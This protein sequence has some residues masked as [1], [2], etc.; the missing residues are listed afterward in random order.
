VLALVSIVTTGC[1]PA[2]PD[3]EHDRP[4]ASAADTS[5][6]GPQRM[7]RFDEVASFAIASRLRSAHPVGDYAATIR[8]DAAA[9]GYGKAGRGPMPPGAMIVEALSPLPEAAPT[10]YYAMV[11]REPGF[12][13]EGGDWEYFVID[14]D[15][16]VTSS[17]K[18]PLCARCH[19]E[20]GREHL[21]EHVPS[22][23]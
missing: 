12:F 19:G 4:S 5:A 7:P 14:P 6:S 10:L 9:V 1:A 17:G 11:R 20:A 16:I 15:G 3:A 8:V 21:F 23:P 22:T 18:L 13:S 2:V